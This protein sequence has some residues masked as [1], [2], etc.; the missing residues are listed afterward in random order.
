MFYPYFINRAMHD[1]TVLKLK[2]LVA[3]DY[4]SASKNS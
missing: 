1:K 3:S 4:K 2:G